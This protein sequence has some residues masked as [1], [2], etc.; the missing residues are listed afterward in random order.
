MYRGTVDTAGRIL[1]KWGF[2]M[3][4]ILFTIFMCI[5]ITQTNNI[6]LQSL[7]VAAI[8]ICGMINGGRYN[9]L[10]RQAEGFGLFAL[11]LDNERREIFSYIFDLKNEEIEKNIRKIMENHRSYRNIIIDKHDLETYKK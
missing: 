5:L 8:I 11:D 3:W 2:I 10:K 1:G 7:E 9:L 4:A 6:L